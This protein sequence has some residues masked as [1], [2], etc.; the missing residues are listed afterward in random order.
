MIPE[1]G[2]QC[3]IC[4]RVYSPRQE[5][6]LYCGGNDS[7]CAIIDKVKKPSD[8]ISWTNNLST[9]TQDWANVS[10]CC[11]AIDSTAL[12]NK[13]EINGTELETAIKSRQ[14]RI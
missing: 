12:S 13:V 1:Q 5:M 10:S 6:C 9:S 7:N 11:G 8:G 3:P 4:K 14:R 2:W